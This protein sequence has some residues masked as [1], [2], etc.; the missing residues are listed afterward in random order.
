[1]VKAYKFLFQR[2]T[3][4][5]LVLAA[6]ILWPAMGNAQNDTVSA[7]EPAVEEF[8]TRALE[9]IEYLEGTLN[10]I[11][12]PK[13]PVS[14][15]EIIINDSYLK[16]FRDEEVQIE[17][18]LDEA[19][20]VILQKDVQAYL[21]DVD[22]FFK[23]A[24]FE[25][26]VEEIEHALN[27]SG[28]LFLKATLNRNLNA[29]TVKGD[30][31][32]TNKPRFIE[33]NVDTESKDLKIVSIY[34]TPLNEN[35][36]LR[37]WWNQL[38]FAWKKVFL[39]HSGI[40]NNDPALSQIKEII[41]LTDIDVSGN[42]YIENLQPL[43]KLTRLEK[44]NCSNTPVVSLFPLRNLSFL[45]HLNCSQT[46]V[47]DLDA[48]R[49]T[50]RL[51]YLNV[52]GTYTADIS[53][54]R[55]FEDLN[56]LNISGTHIDSLQPLQNLKK[57]RELTAS[58]TKVTDL[59]PLAGN[60][61]LS[62]LD[63]SGTM[64]M[65]LAPLRGVPGLEILFIENTPVRDISPLA[66][67]N[68]L[69]ALHA[70]NTSVVALTPV[71]GLPNLQKLY[72]DNAPVAKE[73][74]ITFMEDN[75]DVLFVYES[76]AL[77]N[78]WNG[79]PETWKMILRREASLS[80]QPGKEELHKLSSIE[81]LDISNNMSI[82]SLE[83]LARLS[84]LK[85]LNCNYTAVTALDGIEHLNQLVK[86][87]CENNP[88]TSLDPLRTLHSLEILQ[89]SNT[90]ISDLTPLQELEALKVL[91]I[92]NNPVDSLSALESLLALEFVYADFSRLNRGAVVSFLNKNPDVLV[93]YNTRRLQEWWQEL[94]QDWHAIFKNASAVNDTPTPEDL[95]QILMLKSVTIEDNYAVKTL[96]PLSRL[97]FP[98]EIYIRKTGIT[99]IEPLG[100]MIGLTTVVIEESPVDNVIPLRGL[101]KLIFISLA[102]TPVDDLVPVSEMGQL[103]HLNISGTPVGN[104]RDLRRL[105]NL[106]YLDC[107]S[108]KVNFLG[109]LKGLPNLEK[110][111]CFNAPIVGFSL[112]NFKSANPDTEVIYY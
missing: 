31:L 71:S 10:F 74:A 58:N 83:P 98:E 104:L 18:D 17:D 88:L 46:A 56:T 79:L 34:T 87:Q 47:H 40:T 54:V 61:S 84:K 21:K 51:A 27:D 35:E 48:L 65:S 24:S 23:N 25:F 107:S 86:L 52:S 110:L 94:P 99:G 26:D 70:S 3:R 59:S 53:A 92:E 72:L 14:E 11:G 95:H 22:F 103:E 90:G 37:N 100:D 16:I 60:E 106:K 105:K 49:Y 82:R 93:V 30:T 97:Y 77:E 29:V 89:L 19:R 68:N 42:Q 111:I 15:K 33:I 102:N 1:M 13:T 4:G 45:K 44:L 101:K 64:V 7:A 5:I 57:L 20:E 32:Q 12:D 96:E 43:S 8:K 55:N 9:L 80:S 108:T 63:V 85:R 81:A 73:E 69:V 6:F 39:D 28:R 38:P 112:N 66:E 109:P 62:M 2:Y 91:H 36:V 78:W 75:P 41:S 76:A 67:L 50:S